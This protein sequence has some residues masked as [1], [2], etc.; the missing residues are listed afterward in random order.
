MCKLIKLFFLICALVIT[1]VSAQQQFEL[2]NNFIFSISFITGENEGTEQNLDDNF[3]WMQTQGYTHLRFFGIF[4]NG[5]HA[6]PSPTLDANGFPT[7]PTIEPVLGIM[8]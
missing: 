6:F 4:P 2:V 5:Y 3:Q 8:V 1:D 7:N